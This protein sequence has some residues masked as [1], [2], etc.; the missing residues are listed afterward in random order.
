M[1]PHTPKYVLVRICF[2]VVEI[3]SGEEWLRCDPCYSL[4]RCF[5]SNDWLFTAF[6]ISIYWHPQLYLPSFHYLTTATT[7]CCI[8]W[9]DENA[10]SCRFSP[11]AGL[12][13]GRAGRWSG[14]LLIWLPVNIL[15]I[16][17]CPPYPVLIL[18]VVY[19]FQRR[20]IYSGLIV[21]CPRRWRWPAF[22]GKWIC[23]ISPLDILPV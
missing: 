7:W 21:W 14:P 5:W 16:M 23:F 12:R 20:P 15:C 17:L 2:P 13:G 18:C 11:G 22:Y 19:W 4:W 10:I 6:W 1:C 9:C 3:G 8:L